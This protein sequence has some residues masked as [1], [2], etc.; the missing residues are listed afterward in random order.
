M[1]P[2]AKR[3]QA[4]KRKD[5]MRERAWDWRGRRVE[6]VVGEE[7]GGGVASGEEGGEAGSEEGSRDKSMEKGKHKLTS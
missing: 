6:G 3:K 2:R 4:T 7:P 5:G 1:D